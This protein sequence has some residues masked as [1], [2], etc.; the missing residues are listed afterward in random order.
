M[1]AAV[2]TSIIWYFIR[3]EI[4]MNSLLYQIE[5][6]L[7]GVFIAVSIHLFGMMKRRETK[8]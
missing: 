4:F 2:S 7:V 8:N 3:D 1:I 5:P 6:M